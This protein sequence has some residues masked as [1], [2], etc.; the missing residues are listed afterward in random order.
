PFE[1][2]ERKA[3]HLGRWTV[4]APEGVLV[5][6]IAVLVGEDVS[7]VTASPACLPRLFEL[8][9]LSLEAALSCPDD[10]RPGGSP[11]HSRRRSPGVLLDHV[12]DHLRELAWGKL[13]DD[14]VDHR[15]GLG[16]KG[17]VA[18]VVGHLAHE[19]R[20]LRVLHGHGPPSRLLPG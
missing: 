7:R 5:N 12:L 10:Q 3:P 2:L 20:E 13:A 8:L 15:H 4:R 1:S 18:V 9:K 11:D 19:L 14:L 6:G 17:L 16:A